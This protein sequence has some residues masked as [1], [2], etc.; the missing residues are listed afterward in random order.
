[1]QKQEIVSSFQMSML[2]LAFLTGSSIVNIP[3]PL[4]GAA[5]NG[6]WISVLLAAAMGGLL[7][8]G[9]LYLHRKFPGMTF[10]QYGRQT[11][12]KWPMAMISIPF[13]LTTFSMFSSILVDIGGF[14]SSTMM[15]DTPSFIVQTLF[16]VLS[17]LTA[18]AGIEVMARM[19]VVLIVLMYGAVIVVLVLVAPHY[20]PE[21]LLP[22]IPEGIKPVLHGAYIIYGFPFTEITL[23]SMLLP[24][25]RKEDAGTTGKYMLYAIVICSVVL[26][27]AVICSI[28]AFGPLS[29]IFKFSVFRLARMIQIGEILERVESMIG[30]SLIAG[31]YMKATIVLFILKTALTQLFNLQDDRILTYPAALFGLLLSITS[32]KNE[33]GFLETSLIVWP[34]LSNIMFTV[35]LILIMVVASFRRQKPKGG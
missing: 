7:L 25:I 9:V 29:G 19:F 17:A 1:M 22:V 33:V 14:F 28:M 23:I 15:V 3:A 21:Y 31:S 10:I 8:F 24:F 20:H 30:F 4:T 32:Y 11:L 5:R 35:P 27:A 2:F 18:R 26:V 34:L 12:G 16:I 13:L 6:A